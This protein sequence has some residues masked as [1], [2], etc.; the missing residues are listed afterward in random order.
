MEF[1]SSLTKHLEFEAYFCH[2]HYTLHETAASLTEH[3]QW[4]KEV[5]VQSTMITCS[6]MSFSRFNK[7]YSE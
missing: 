2:W 7:N 1:F 3:H 6:V 5:A 4:M